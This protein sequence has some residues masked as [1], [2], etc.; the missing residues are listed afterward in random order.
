MDDASTIG[1]RAGG[2]DCR[3][4]RPCGGW[5]D[6]AAVSALGRRAEFVV[7][8]VVAVTAVRTRGETG[9][10]L[11]GVGT[12]SGFDATT[13]RR[14]SLVPAPRRDEEFGRL[15]LKVED[16]LELTDCAAGGWSSDATGATPIS[17]G[18]DERWGDWRGEPRLDCSDPVSSSDPFGPPI[19]R[20][21]GGSG[22]SVSDIG[23]TAARGDV[24]DDEFAD[25]KFSTLTR[26]T[27]A[28][29][30]RY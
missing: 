10:E 18:C 11:D 14:S 27:W 15:R 1:T 8:V 30:C 2:G 24:A 25:A 12:P 9:S 6:R 17:V 16:V 22:R 26:L 19:T 4:V 5:G 3:P 28:R 7:A 13:T 20:E 29:S 23:T 21:T